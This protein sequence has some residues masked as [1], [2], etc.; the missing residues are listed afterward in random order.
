MAASGS[1]ASGS[2]SA[3]ARWDVEY[4]LVVLGAGVSGM[5]AAL[6]ASIEGLRVLVIEKSSQVGGTSAYSSGTVWIPNNPEQRRAGITGE[7]ETVLAYLDALVGPRADRAM[8]EAFVS[9]GPEMLR[10]LDKHTDIRWLM[11]DL[12]PDYHQELPGAAVGGRPLMPLPFDGRTLGNNF[13]RVRWPLPELMLFGGMMITRGEA[14]RLM[15]VG[16]NIDSLVLGARLCGRFLADRTRYKRGTRLVL[17]NALVAKLFKQLL[18]RGAA[19]RFKAQATRLIVEEGRLAG[20][21]ILHEGSEV[22]VRAARGLVMAG[23]GFPASSTLR[24]RHLPKPVAKYTSAFEGCTGDTL[25]LAREIGAAFGPSGEDNSFWFPSSIALRKDGSTAVYPHIILDRAK[26]GLIAVN[27]AGR[28]FVDEAISYHRFVREMYRSHSSVPCI[29]AML[30]CDRRFVW[31]YG[32]GLIRPYTPF[33]K[34]F[35]DR[36]YLSV[37]DSLEEL[38]KKIGVDARG[39]VETVR[40]QNGYALTGIDPEFGKGD[41]PYDRAYGDADHKPNPCLGPIEKP[42]FCAVAVHPT[43]LGTSLGLLTNRHAQVLDGSR[44]PIPGLY[45]CGNDMHSALGGEYPGPG[46]Q[47]GLGMTFGYIAAKHAAA[48]G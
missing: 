3:D 34:P 43:P 44:R 35:V 5:T 11:Y 24:E 15:R 42:P 9:E 10:F 2:R 30:V 4:D 25:L 21:V 6:V 28:R 33:L 47:L 16:R 48:T 29:P 27:V 23:G 8:R 46:A 41:N 32:L 20:L 38:A 14:S 18:D 17:G 13:D 1:G 45:A 19:F 7:A 31:K 39:L 12:Q 22:R 26:P 37:A 40:A 36:G